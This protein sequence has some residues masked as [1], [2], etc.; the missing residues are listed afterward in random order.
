MR[1]IEVS[2]YFD[3]VLE[4][5]VVATT[6]VN[7]VIGSHVSIQSTYKMLREAVINPMNLEVIGSSLESI[8]EFNNE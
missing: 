8:N 5:K 1:F 3:L 2:F 4:D 6:K 7:R